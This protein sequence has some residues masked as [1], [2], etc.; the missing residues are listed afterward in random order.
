MSEPA[1]VAVQTIIKDFWEYDP[2]TNAWTQKADFGGKE[3]NGA[4]GFSVGNKGYIGTG[5]DSSFYYK[6]FWQYDPATDVWTRKA[7]FGGTERAHAVGFSIGNK[8]YIGTG[9]AFILKDFWEYDP[10]T[11]TWTQ[12]ADFGG[13]GRDFAVGFSIGDKG[14]IGTGFDDSF[15]YVK[16]FWIY[17]PATDVWNRKADF[18]GEARDAVV[19]FSVGNKGYMG[20]G[21][22]G[23][24]NLSDFW[25]YTPDGT[26]T[27]RD[28]ILVDNPIMYWRLGESSGETAYDESPNQRDATYIHHPA[29]GQK[30]AISNDPDT[31]VGFNRRNEFVVWNPRLGYSGEFTVEA[32][33]KEE[34]VH[35]IETFF[36]TRSKIGEFSFDFK[37][38][39]LAGK[40]IHFDVGDGDRWLST[41]S[42][43]FNFEPHVWYYVV[44]V[45]T[46]RGATYY[47]NGSAL[48]SVRYVGNP[49][50]FDPA[51]R[52]EIGGNIRYGTEWFDGRVDE[53]AVYDYALTPDQIAAHY[54]MGIGANLLSHDST[55][56]SD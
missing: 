22:N 31:A 16:D 1:L 19:G 38:D 51:H 18:G 26:T 20:T 10:T 55:D 47:V 32:W 3:R 49:L 24:G 39:T 6:D 7:D 4:V 44:A 27:Y 33:V 48:G 43:P 46:A 30:G 56:G 17:D 9:E 5:R 45:V 52:V 40:E 41:S 29:L 37:F 23:G 2:I 15:A 53:V 21:Y 34:R 13:G 25:E 50:L 35:P 14:Y 54:S 36:N 11:N 8:G 42:V 28:T 12:K